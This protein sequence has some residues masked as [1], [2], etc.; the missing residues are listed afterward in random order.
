MQLRGVNIL[1]KGLEGG[2]VVPRNLYANLMRGGGGGPRPILR[3]IRCTE[4][5]KISKT[6]QHGKTA[7]SSR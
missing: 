7:N 2:V 1:R 5:S 4:K 3:K 6:K